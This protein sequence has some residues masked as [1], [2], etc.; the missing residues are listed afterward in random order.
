MKELTDV[1]HEYLQGEIIQHEEKNEKGNFL[2]IPNNASDITS[3]EMIPTS[4][5]QV[6]PSCPF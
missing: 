4:F 6:K 5:Y 2:S 3:A 1:M